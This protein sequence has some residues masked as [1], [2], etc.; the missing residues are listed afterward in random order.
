[1]RAGDHELRLLAAPLPE[2][3]ERHLRDAG[4][5]ARREGEPD[6]LGER[7]D[8]AGAGLTLREPEVRDRRAQAD[9]QEREQHER[10]AGSVRVGSLDRADGLERRLELELVADRDAVVALLGDLRLHR[11][12]ARDRVA[13]EVDPVPSGALVHADRVGVVVARD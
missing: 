1:M 3:R 6:L 2:Q 11:P 7:G 5:I 12:G 9:D 4:E 13:P 10:H 8:R